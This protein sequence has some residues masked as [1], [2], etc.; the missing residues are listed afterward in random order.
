M[1]TAPSR[2]KTLPANST[3][4]EAYHLEVFVLK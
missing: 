2:Q 3:W 4:R 1:V